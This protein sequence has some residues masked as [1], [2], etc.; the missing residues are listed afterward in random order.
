MKVIIA[1]SS[2]LIV[3]LDTN[4]F[5]LLFKLF[6]EVIISDEVYKEISY[7]FDHK[8]RI[9]EYLLSK[10]LQIYR[11]ANDDL[12]E[13]LVKRLDKGE[14]ESIILAKKFSLPLIIDERKGRSIA[15][16]LDIIIIGFVGIVL[17]LLEKNIIKKEQAIAIVKHAELNDFR[18]S[19]A[20]KKMV[21]EY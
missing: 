9:E 14:S 6:E 4:N 12:Y 17:K 5:S 8:T 21:F 3:L 2:T 7:K 16:S 20:L 19:N 13:M 18:L 11:V 15:K 10:A 1:D